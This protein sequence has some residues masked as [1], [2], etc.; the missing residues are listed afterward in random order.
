MVSGGDTNFCF[1]LGTGRSC[2]QFS[3]RGERHRP[4]SL[5]VSLPFFTALDL[6]S[7]LLVFNPAKRITIEECLDHAFISLYRDP[8]LD[9]DETMDVDS[10][11]GEASLGNS[12]SFDRM[13]RPGCF[14]CGG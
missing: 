8:E 6:I 7:K 13:V 10:V 5:E 3:A 11:A 4:S 12:A 14:S 9:E 2:C 1:E